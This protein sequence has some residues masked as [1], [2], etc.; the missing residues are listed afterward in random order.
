VVADEVP[1]TIKQIILTSETMALKATVYKADL[2]IAD[3]D[4]QYYHSHA[5][6]LAQ[7]PS[8]TIERLMIRLLVF[9]LH[10]HE[11][12]A[13]TRGLSTA[14]EPD[15]WQKLLTDEIDLWIDLGQPDEKRIR[16]ACGRAREVFIYTYDKRSADVW[17]KQ[18]KNKL[19][20]FDNLHVIALPGDTGVSLAQLAQRSM[21][22]Q[23]SIQDNEVWLGDNR[24]SV[25]VVPERLK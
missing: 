14:D 18:L 16:K 3:M 1:Y 13:F 2:Q 23:C 8:E 10:A 24:Q 20:R 6:T 9:A 12:L 17:W 5:L 25:H 15:L 7:H 11:D 4:R 22:L 21:G 19:G